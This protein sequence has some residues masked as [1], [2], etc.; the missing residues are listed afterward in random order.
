MNFLD[1][2][3]SSGYITVSKELARE[4]G[5]QETIILSELI[6]HYEYF[7]KE[8][9]L[10]QDGYFYCTVGKLKKN[11]TI[12]KKTQS[13]KINNLIELGLIEKKLKGLPAK[14]HFKINENKL[15]NLFFDQ[16]LDNPR[17]LQ[18]GQN[19][20]SR[21][22]KSKQQEEPKRTSINN[23]NYNNNKT[24][25]EEGE[26]IPAKFDKKFQQ[27]FNRKLSVDLY[28]KL[29]KIYSDSKI[30]FKALEVAEENAD[31]PS[32]MLQILSD[33]Q[34]KGLTSVSQVN[35]YLKKRKASKSHYKPNT[36][37]DNYKDE[38]LYNVEQLKKKG[39][40]S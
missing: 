8:N 16:N 30:L 9:K 37:S 33:W 10:D 1:L 38:D 28:Q 32:Y 36:G 22:D 19:D 20:S 3:K 25:E 13:R 6:S 5:L 12:P 7:K 35:A 40:N 31:K 26:K 29:T 17:Q 15:L 27:V 18:M 2:I 21:S 24:E 23:N 11:T 4:I 14:R 34:N 39:W